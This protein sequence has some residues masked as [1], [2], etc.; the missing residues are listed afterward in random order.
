MKRHQQDIERITQNK[1]NS[2]INKFETKVKTLVEV[3][4]LSFI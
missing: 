2:D 4:L 1:I 3:T